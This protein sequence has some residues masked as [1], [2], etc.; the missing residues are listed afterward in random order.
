MH[1]NRETSGASRPDGNETGLR[2]PKTTRRRRTLSRSRTA[3]YYRRTRRGE[4][5]AGQ[6]VHRFIQHSPR[7]SAGKPSAPGTVPTAKAKRSFYAGS[8]SRAHHVQDTPPGTIGLF[9]PDCLASAF[10]CQRLAIRTIYG[11]SVGSGGVRQI[12]RLGD[13]HFLSLPGD[14]QSW[15][16][17]RLRNVF[18]DRFPSFDPWHPR[19]KH[20]RIVGPEG[21]R[22]I[23]VVRAGSGE[24]V[25]VGPV[26]GCFL[27]RK[28]YL[29]RP[30]TPT[31]VSV[32][33]KK[34]SGLA[35][36][37]TDDE[38]PSANATL[39]P[40][41]SIAVKRRHFRLFISFFSLIAL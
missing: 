33:E 16:G 34:S 12:A 19:D 24:P 6:G 23:W 13:F 17:K 25:S 10:L 32:V 20:G 41:A 22:A 37:P 39:A 29:A 11:Y 21:E 4:K 9:F 30:V 36:V 1:E 27:S 38:A 2:R 15:G 31:G 7:H 26:N 18:T 40:R 8:L 5:G 35:S 28:V 3:S 14:G